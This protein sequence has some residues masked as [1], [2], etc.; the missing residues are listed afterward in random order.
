MR[1]EVLLPQVEL[2]MESAL[3]AKWLVR[4]G[5]YVKAEQPLVE[6]ETQKATSDVQSPF[7][8]FVRE[9]CVKEGETV[10][11]KALLCILTD[12]AD[13]AFD[14]SAPTNDAPK[15]ETRP[16]P[17]GGVTDAPN[18]GPVKATPVARRIAKELGVDL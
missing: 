9:L 15:Q 7:A 6:V 8:G 11:E 1:R 10:N 13:E 5:D 4:A 14:G 12:S 17:P 2:T 18:D 3:I 16:A